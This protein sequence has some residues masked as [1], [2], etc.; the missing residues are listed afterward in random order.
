MEWVVI[1]I[2][3]LSCV[4]IG[5]YFNRKVRQVNTLNLTIK[6]L[7]QEKDKNAEL[8]NAKQEERR[9]AEQLKEEAEE[10]E[11]EINKRVSQANETVKKLVNDGKAIAEEQLNREMELVREQ[12]KKSLLREHEELLGRLI[13][14]RVELQELITPLKEELSEYEKKRSAVIEALKREQELENEKDFHRVCL[15]DEA[16]EDISYVKGILDK[17]HQ[18]AVVAEVIY[19]AYIQEPAKEMINRVVGLGK[20][21]GIYKITNINTKESYIGQ[22]VNVGARLMQHIKGTLG[23]QSIAD[24]RIHREMAKVGIE[25]WTFEVLEECEKEELTE[26]EKYYILYYRSNEFGFNKRLG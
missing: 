15:S 8:L 9:R 16:I 19:K 20:V 7:K 12:R 2:L 4:G 13:T 11:R 1:I 5:L 22:G 14:E 25:N 21:S 23:L 26:R 3:I 18:K 24:Q 17:L 10:R 6:E